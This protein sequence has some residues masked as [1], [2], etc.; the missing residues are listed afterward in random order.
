MEKREDRQ[1]LEMLAA[2]AKRISETDIAEKCSYAGV[3]WDGE[4]KQISLESFGIRSVISLPECTADPPMHIWQHLAILHYLCEVGP[5]P[6]LEAW[7][8]MADL[9]DGGAVRGSS[10]DREVD[11]MVSMRLGKH[12][13][14]HIIKAVGS[15]GGEINENPKADLCALFRF[16]PRYPFL[17]NM[18]F[19]DDEFPASGRILVDGSVSPYLGTEANGTVA[20]LLVQ[21][22]CDAADRA[23]QADTEQ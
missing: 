3:G 1:F 17:F 11:R 18:W 2:A 9:R 21:M 6:S 15:L 16:M 23:A 13:S 14:G 10:F 19:A 8:S 20:S 5:S 12:S 7:G 22:L 4:R